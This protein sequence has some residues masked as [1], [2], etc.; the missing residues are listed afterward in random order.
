MVT[1]QPETKKQITPPYLSIPK[2]EDVI[3]YAS[4]RNL[5]N[6]SSELFKNYGFNDSDAILAVST[7][8]FLGVVD[9]GGQPTD[10][11]AKFRLKGVARKR[12]LESIIR[13]SYKKLFDATDAPQN[14]PQDELSNEFVV[15][16]GM[17]PRVVRS[18]VLAFL[19]LAEFGGLK[20]EGSV[21]G[22]KRTAKLPS[23]KSRQQ[24]GKMA[25]RETLR[26]GKV[27]EEFDSSDFHLQPIVKG[28][29][30]VTI[31]ED[32]FLRTSTDDDLND[33]WR[34]VL[35]AAHKFAEQYL[36]NEISDQ[37]G[38]EEG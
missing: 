1:N 15:Q 31:P 29:M 21:T 16:Y 3:N 28:K 18:A 6:V 26:K 24:L 22:R 27:V 13:S 9:D 12:E 36:K 23:D 10:L 35:K 20:E 32:I 38:S 5:T 2:L 14:L 33:A 30:S 34:L 19:K 4:N 37:N 7:L 11:M 25:A 8:K 17:T